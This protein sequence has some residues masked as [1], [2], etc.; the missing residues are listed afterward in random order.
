MGAPGPGVLDRLMDRFETFSR[1]ALLLALDVFGGEKADHLS[2]IDGLR[3]S[4]I[5]IVAD[6]RNVTSP[7]G[8]TAVATLVGQVAML[9][10]T[11]ELDIA[12]VPLAAPQPPFRGPALAGALETYCSD[13]IGADGGTDAQPA[14]TLLLGDT[15]W[16]GNGV[17]F[18]VCGDDWRFR[19][20]PGDGADTG[21]AWDGPAAAFGAFAAASAGA[22]EALRAALPRVADAVG[23]PVAEGPWWSLDESRTVEGNLRVDGLDVLELDLGQVDIISSGAIT[24]AM[25]Y[26]LLR[27]PELRGSMRTFDADVWLR[28]TSTGIRSR[29]PRMSAGTRSTRS[30]TTRRTI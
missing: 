19:V 13:L 14:L 16:R 8:Q 10:V 12:D 24:T 3:A 5:R 7:A 17:A 6:R 27:A 11:V 28:L 30:P 29:S 23:R 18:R 4:V 2:I 22:A 1:T 15:P 20:I 25:L 9:G 21:T 26:C